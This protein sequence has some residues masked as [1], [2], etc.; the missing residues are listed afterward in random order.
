VPS[1][2]LDWR[3]KQG[4]RPYSRKRGAP[5]EPGQVELS[6]A[7]QVWLA[8][9]GGGPP[10]TAEGGPPWGGV[11]MGTRGGGSEVLRGVMAELWRRE[12]RAPRRYN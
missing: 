5:L 12:V 6:L 11:V 10:E 3:A 7:R 9:R 8:S 4:S 1:L 2:R